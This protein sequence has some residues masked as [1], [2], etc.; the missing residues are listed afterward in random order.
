MSSDFEWHGPGL[1]TL[2]D[3]AF[4]PVQHLVGQAHREQGGKLG[5]SRFEVVIH[6]QQIIGLGLDL[7]L[8]PRPARGPAFKIGNPN[9][10]IKGHPQ[11]QPAD[12][13]MGCL[14][15]VSACRVHLA[16][17]LKHPQQSFGIQLGISFVL[18]LKDAGIPQRQQVMQIF[19]KF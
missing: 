19:R 13:F 9:N 8:N 1:F 12:H 17:S 18:V 7:L 16:F 10:V 6:L 4:V 15:S 14:K 3:S 2:R 5:R 11:G